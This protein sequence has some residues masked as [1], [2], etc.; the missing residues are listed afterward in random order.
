MKYFLLTAFVLLVFGCK[1]MSN[2]ISSEYFN[3][4]N[5]YFDVGN[6]EKAIDYYTQALKEKNV[7]EN[8]IRFNLAVSL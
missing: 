6:Y 8:R 2:D 1:T 5:A 4:G 7:M 3:I